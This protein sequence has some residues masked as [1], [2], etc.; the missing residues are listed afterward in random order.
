MVLFKVKEK[1]LDALRCFLALCRKLFLYQ[2]L[3]NM[4]R[5]LG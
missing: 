2:R 5:K 1:I 3:L 4:D